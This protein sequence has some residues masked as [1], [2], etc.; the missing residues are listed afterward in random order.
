M[1]KYRLLINKLKI[2][3]VFICM[4]QL[5]FSCTDEVIYNCTIDNTTEYRIDKIEFSCSI[6]E[7]IISVPPNSVSNKFQLTYT[8]NVGRF[9]V[10][11]VVCV[12]ITEY[13][14]STKTYKN[15][16]GN[17]ISISDMPVN[18]EFVVEYEQNT[19]YPTNIFK[20]TIR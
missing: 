16:I 5:F 19:L 1:K 4:G 14:D 2:L 9:F 10:E 6:N 13:S 18:T 8:K 17:V 11:P 20:V 3:F 15:T 12:T 7:K